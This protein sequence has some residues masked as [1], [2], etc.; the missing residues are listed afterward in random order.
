MEAERSR[1][2]KGGAA[3]ARALG[4]PETRKSF[5]S[6]G[7]TPGQEIVLA[8]DSDSVGDVF[9]RASKYPPPATVAIYFEETERLEFITLHPGLVDKPPTEDISGASTIGMLYEYIERTKRH[10]TNIRLTEWSASVQVQ[11]FAG[12]K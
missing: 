9:A 8:L 3:L 10:R 11:E 1:R 7:H 5:A 2:L 4:R 6:N 12:T